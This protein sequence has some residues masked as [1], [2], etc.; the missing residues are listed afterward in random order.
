MSLERHKTKKWT[1]NFNGSDLLVEEECENPHHGNMF[2]VSPGYY[3]P[4]KRHPKILGGK[5][6]ALWSM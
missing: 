3:S 6:G 4:P 2:P 5:Q 1:I